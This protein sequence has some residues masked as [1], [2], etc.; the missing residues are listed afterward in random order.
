MQLLQKFANRLFQNYFYDSLTCCRSN[1]TPATDAARLAG[2]LLDRLPAWRPLVRTRLTFWHHFTCQL[3]RLSPGCKTRIR[4]FVSAHVANTRHLE[5]RQIGQI[6]LLPL[7]IFF[8][9]VVALFGMYTHP[10]FINEKC[11]EQISVRCICAAS[12][13]N[14]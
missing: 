6:A 8:V 4:M 10:F 7:L 2:L 9:V 1:G 14:I 12:K 11:L 13:W 3:Q 5:N